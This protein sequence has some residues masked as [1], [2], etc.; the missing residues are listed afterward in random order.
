MKKDEDKG[1][2]SPCNCGGACNCP[3]CPNR[4]K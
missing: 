3:D 2:K 1:T 4:N